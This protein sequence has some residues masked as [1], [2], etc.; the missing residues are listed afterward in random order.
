[1]GSVGNCVHGRGPCGPISN[2]RGWWLLSDHEDVSEKK[3]NI[4]NKILKKKWGKN[5]KEKAILGKK[6]LG[7]NILGKKTSFESCSPRTAAETSVLNMMTQAGIVAVGEGER[8]GRGRHRGRAVPKRGDGVRQEPPGCSQGRAPTF[9]VPQ[10]NPQM[11]LGSPL[12]GRHIPPL[13]LPS[14]GWL[15][16]SRFG[17]WHLCP[18]NL[19]FFN[20]FFCHIA[21]K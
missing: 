16:Q 14:S 12:S 5:H 19:S 4:R 8:E 6:V 3:N 1:M 11:C 13:P 20:F 15:N 17:G 21:K 18:G 2:G 7:K 9:W 10:Q